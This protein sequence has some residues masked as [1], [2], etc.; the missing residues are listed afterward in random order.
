MKTSKHAP[1]T[2][3]ERLN[4]SKA[5]KI[6]QDKDRTTRLLGRLRWKA[7][8]LMV[9]YFKS[10]EVLQA[11]NQEHGQETHDA[12]AKQAESMFKIDFFEFYT[13]LERY[14]TVC[15]ATLG[16][17]VSAAA[18][19]NNVNALRYITNPDLHH[20]RPLASHAFHANLLEALDDENCPLHSS[21]GVQDVRIQLGLAK[22]YRNAWKDADEKDGTTRWDAEDGAS[23]KN[24]KLT[25]LA[26]ES[27][28]RTLVIGCA[29]A[30]DVVQAYAGP[31]LN[32][33]SLSSHDFEPPAYAY[34]DVVV[35][36][37][38]LE[39]MDDAMELD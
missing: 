38:P 31:E 28:L 9:S 23:P 21:L 37:V 12:L 8:L 7:E 25:E 35:G 24:V 13:F 11:N 10:L 14:I 32:G 20:T 18:P 15:L 19:R 26:L 6:R 34:E 1:K 16:V 39:Y 22:D 3:L 27:M 30:H 5:D 4:Q 17:S 36:D 33:N 29:H 2:P